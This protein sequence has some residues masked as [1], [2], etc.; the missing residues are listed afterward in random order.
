MKTKLVSALLSVLIAFGLWFYVVT[1]VN[2]EWEDTFYNVPVVL[3]NESVL[4]DKGLMIASKESYSIT[5]RLKGNRTDLSSLKSSDITV[6]ADLS[7]INEA[8]RQNVRYDVDF[9]GDIADNAIEILT[10]SPDWITLEIVEWITKEIPI[11]VTYQDPTTGEET[12]VPYDYIA[13]KE[14]VALSHQTVS[15]TGPK[16]VVDQITQARIFI[17]LAGQTQTISQK[18]RYTL[19]NADNEPVDA[20]QITTNVPEVTAELKIQRVKELNLL[21]DVKYGGGATK[22]NTTIT[23]DPQTITVAGNDIQLESLTNLTIGSINLTELT[24]DTVLEFPVTLPEN[25]T[26]ITGISTVTVTVQFDDLVVKELAI[27]AIKIVNPPQGMTV[28]LKTKVCLIVVRG[29]SEQIEAITEENVSIEVDLTGAP[30]GTN[31]YKAQVYIDSIFSGV[32][33]M[34]SDPITVELKTD[35]AP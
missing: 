23:L 18:Y 12:D 2:P 4:N 30:V 29:P 7:K 14:S 33:V 17:N 3:N 11:V 24:E 10:R 28:D 21:L 6:I 31:N 5:L 20:A 9:P 25:I 34:K 15:V 16:S 32:G 1:V 19:C 35:E 8:G 27:P 26:N 13:D 22:G